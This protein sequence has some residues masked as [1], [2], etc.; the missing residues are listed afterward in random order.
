VRA[1]LNGPRTAVRLSVCSSSCS[2]SI[3]ALSRTASLSLVAVMCENQV[4]KLSG[5][6][7]RSSSVESDDGWRISGCDTGFGMGDVRGNREE[8]DESVAGGGDILQEGSREVERE[9]D[10]AAEAVV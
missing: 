5:L 10:G 9:G 1:H 8:S 4:L 3:S 2:A 6:S 7:S